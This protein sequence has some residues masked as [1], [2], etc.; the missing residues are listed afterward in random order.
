MLTVTKSQFYQE[1][2]NFLFQQ[3]N[4][5]RHILEQS[6]N[7]EN[8]NNTYIP[9]IN[10]QN[11]NLD[12]LCQKFNLSPFERD[13]LLLC[14]G[15]EIDPNFTELCAKI[16]GN[17]KKNYPT[18]SLALSCF[19]NPSW[20]VISPS[21]PL[22]K[23]DLLEF[24]PDLTITQAPIKIDKRIFCYLLGENAFDQHLTGRIYPIPENFQS[25]FLAQSQLDL[26]QQMSKIWSHSNLNVYPILQLCGWEISSKYAIAFQTCQKLGID[27]KVLS[28]N[29][30]PTEA[31]ELN[32]FTRRW[33]RE[34][35][36]SNSVLLL[37]CDDINSENRVREMAI[38]QFIENL[39]TLLI[40]SSYNRHSTRYKPLISFDVPSLSH[41]EQKTLWE[42]HLGDY[43]TQLNGHL[44]QVVSQFNLS[45]NAIESAC[46][47]IKSEIENEQDLPKQLWNYCRS[48]ARPKLDD[49]AQYIDSHASWEDLI[50][51]EKQKNILKDME[52]HLKH[53]AK[54]Y[55][56]W[57][58]GGRE[59][60]G[61]GVTSLFSGQ[62][63]TGKTM[64]AGVLA[65]TL[66]LDLY[67]IDLSTV[68]SKYIGET[69]KNLR[70]I[71]DA[72]ETG[73][74]ILLFDE[75]DALFGKRT[76]VKDS[77]D[78]H[79]NVE[80]SYL[81]QR[82][83][84]YQGL[85][86]LT[87]NLKSSLD[88]AFLRRIRFVIPFPFPDED[89]RSEIW[90]RAFPP[91]TP[92]EGLDFWRLGALNLAGGNIKNIALNAAVF[93]AEAGESVMMKHI[94]RATQAE[95]IKLERTLTEREIYGWV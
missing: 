60:R 22:Q 6:L 81:L 20:Q 10:C 67:R 86:I 29:L 80:V 70:K 79:A 38:S 15:I 83:E 68:V 53:R 32:H 61:L 51:P 57:G 74:A 62:S 63:G 16:N 72:A 58:F 94:L 13:I 55:E 39:N 65:K 28:A 34:S 37:D 25:T 7:Q 56:D 17:P 85:A 64:A 19:P 50:L 36:L 5:V 47:T 92:T 77:H 40:I 71:F 24:S 9:N 76:E 95:Y 11:S 87:T 27:L 88:Q 43:S 30:L 3:V 42:S 1:N 48:Q 73:G 26:I 35:I 21:Y 54:I 90:K 41:Y 45:P 84:S 8:Q 82:M 75:A 31:Q 91:K 18:L 4:Q 44:S 23:W 69:E 33:E 52:A 12:S 46:L 2:L 49:L 89:S 59:K 14:V 78:R 66:N 93:A